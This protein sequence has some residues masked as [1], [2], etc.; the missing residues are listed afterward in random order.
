M[1]ICA[2]IR[3]RSPW[4]VCAVFLAVAGML[5]SDA[6]AARLSGQLTQNGTGN[7]QFFL[8]VVRL[9]LSNPVVGMDNLAAPGPWSVDVPDGTYFIVAY[10]DVNGNLL[11]SRGEP[12]G[13]YG[14][15]FPA[16]VQVQ[17]ADIS[18]LDMNLG[19]F[20]F[21]A[22]LDGKVAYTGNKTGRIWIV[23]H[24]TPTLTLTTTRGI[25]W[26]MTSPGEFEVFVFQDGTYYVTSYMDLDGNLLFD[27]GEPSGKVGPIEILATPGTTYRN[28]DIT[29]QDDPNGIQ[30]TTWSRVKGLYER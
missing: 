10:R 22:A 25:P 2:S 24:V 20:Q 13:F 29:L 8:Y 14:S 12:M 27:E 4:R 23:P 18:G 9:S 3:G 7:G 28:L 1:R 6:M 30:P 16:R 17:G 5:A 15:P 19:T 21:A 26:T 11:P